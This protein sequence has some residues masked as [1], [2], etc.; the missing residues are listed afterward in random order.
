MPH[1]STIDMSNLNLSVFTECPEA[2][3][4]DNY[5]AS[6]LSVIVGQLHQVHLQSSCYYTRFC[7]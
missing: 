7:N 4:A 6:Q 5:N 1:Q 3:N 2:L